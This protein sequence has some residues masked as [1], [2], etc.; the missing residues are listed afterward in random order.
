M[1]Q[2][3]DISV[4]ELCLNTRG[5]AYGAVVLKLLR[6]CSAIQRLKL[7]DQLDTVILP[8]IYNSR[9]KFSYSLIFKNCCFIR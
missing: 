6:T 2:F 4:L 7:V 3:P 9:N 8:N 1:F 5:H